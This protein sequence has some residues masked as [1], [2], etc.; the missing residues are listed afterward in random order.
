MIELYL[1]M[2]NGTELTIEFLETGSV[3]NPHNMLA[4][5][6]H[7]VYARMVQNTKIYF[8]KRRQMMEVARAYD[9]FKKVIAYELAYAQNNKNQGKEHLDYI[10]G[11]LQYNDGSRTYSMYESKRIFNVTFSAKNAI[12]YYI[13]RNRQDRKVKNLRKILEEYIQKQKKQKEL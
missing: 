9:S 10:R 8:L 13:M 2:D 12:M 11:S 4:R 3:L 1:I 7:N 5:R 6:G